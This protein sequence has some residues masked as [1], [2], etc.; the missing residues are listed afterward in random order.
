MNLFFRQKIIIAVVV[1]VLLI[2]NVCLYKLVLMQING[3]SNERLEARTLDLEDDIRDRI[4]IYS[5]FMYDVAALLSSTDNLKQS[6]WEH[7]ME[8]AKMLDRYPGMRSVVYAPVI[9]AKQRTIFEATIKQSSDSSFSIYP[10]KI[11]E[12]VAPVLFIEPKTRDGKPLKVGFNILSDSSRAAAVNFARDNNEL[13][14]TQKVGLIGD[15]NGVSEPGFVIYLPIYKKNMPLNS[16]DQ[17]RAAFMGVVAT[18]IRVS[19]LVNGLVGNYYK[20][21]YFQIFDGHNGETLRSEN[22][23]YNSGSEKVLQP[24]YAPTYSKVTKIDWANNSWYIRYITP[25]NFGLTN[26]E[27]SLPLIMTGRNIVISILLLW[28]LWRTMVNRNKRHQSV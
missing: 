17:R 7:Y 2:A 21:L 23:M 10:D 6:E 1:V 26:F 8:T 4:E 24:G 20:D 13:A 11:T 16:V 27:K 9:D 14:I 5:N 22:M 18:G 19:E 25:P 3:T 15:L 12:Q 28:L